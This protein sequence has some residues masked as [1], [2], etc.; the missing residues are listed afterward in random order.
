MI[1]IGASAF[2]L[3]A[4]DSRPTQPRLFL[5]AVVLGLAISGMHYTA[6]AG[7]RLD[8]L[9]FDTSRFVGAD[10]ALVAQYAWR[11]LPRSSRSAFPAPFFSRWSRMGAPPSRR[12]RAAGRRSPLCRPAPAHA[13]EQ[14][15]FTDPPLAR[16]AGRSIRVEKDGRWRDIAVDD[17][18][19]IRANAH[20]TYVH[21]GEQEYFCN[22]SIS[23]LEARLD[24]RPFLRVHRSHIVSVRP[25]RAREARGRE[26]R[27][28]NSDSLCGAASRLR[29]PIIARSSSGP[30]AIAS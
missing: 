20:Y 27:L 21:D 14:A 8:P 10:S 22:L 2:A 28:R 15:P 30:S 18:F 3:W 19:A 16:A 9:C 25:N 17:I 12:A 23:A 26:R 11:C 1:A 13:V 4:L 24:P 6:M 5:G 7:M 29:A